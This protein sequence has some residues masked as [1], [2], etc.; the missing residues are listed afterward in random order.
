MS[1]E[2]FV[3]QLRLLLNTYGL[4][5]YALYARFAQTV[6]P[7]GK[8]LPAQRLLR[9]ARATNGWPKKPLIISAP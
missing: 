6:G 4:R 1:H 2:E 8:L 3:S 5:D 7:D 9:A